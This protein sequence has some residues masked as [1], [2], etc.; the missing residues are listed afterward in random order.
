MCVVMDICV[1][2]FNKSVLIFSCFAFKTYF[3][4]KSIDFGYGNNFSSI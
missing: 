1:I 2:K 4:P 3:T